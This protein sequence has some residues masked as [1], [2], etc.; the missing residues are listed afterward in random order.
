MI[1]ELAAYV[2]PFSLIFNEAAALD[3]IVAGAGR[4]V[5]PSRVLLGLN[6]AA[7]FLTDV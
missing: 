7:A 5:Q 2:P 6:G 1:L 4:P 3:R